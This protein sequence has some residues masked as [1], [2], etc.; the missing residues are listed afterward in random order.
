MP[1]TARS[2]MLPT[3]VDR[4]RATADAVELLSQQFGELVLTGG[5]PRSVRFDSAALAGV[6]VAI[7]APR[8]APAMP[9]PRRPPRWPRHWSGAEEARRPPGAPR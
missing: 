3:F 8:S 7:T 9:T 6:P 4:R 5:M 2:S 1:R